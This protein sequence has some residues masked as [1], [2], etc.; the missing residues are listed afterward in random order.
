M[1][2]NKHEMPGNITEKSKG[3]VGDLTLK[4]PFLS[5]TLVRVSDISSML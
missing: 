4:P 2:D 5:L 3:T 1:F